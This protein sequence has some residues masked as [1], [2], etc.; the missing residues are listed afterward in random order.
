MIQS[1][2]IN[3]MVKAIRTEEPIFIVS[4]NGQLGLVHPLVIIH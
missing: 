3:I 1:I 2:N 4:H